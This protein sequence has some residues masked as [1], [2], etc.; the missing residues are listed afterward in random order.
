MTC[1]TSSSGS[2]SSGSS[3]CLLYVY[4]FFLSRYGRQ[5]Y[6]YCS[7]FS[8]SHG[9]LSRATEF[10]LFRG[11]LILP[12]NFTEFCRILLNFAEFLEMTDD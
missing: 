9:I 5:H 3:I 8:A 7:Q 4:G 1:N 12:E 6:C 10:A 11:I 2:S